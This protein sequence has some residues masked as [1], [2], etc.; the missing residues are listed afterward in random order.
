MQKPAFDERLFLTLKRAES[1]EPIR[2]SYIWLRD[3][4]RCNECYNHETFQRSLSILD[5]PEDVSPSSYEIRDGALN[6]LC[7]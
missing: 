7:K 3:H 6:V 4:C 2:V 1:D 5:V